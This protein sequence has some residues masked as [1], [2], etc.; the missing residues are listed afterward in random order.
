MDARWRDF[1]GVYQRDEQGFAKL[2][3]KESVTPAADVEFPDLIGVGVG[4]VGA[5]TIRN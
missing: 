1:L 5:F 2:V 3:G 4:Q